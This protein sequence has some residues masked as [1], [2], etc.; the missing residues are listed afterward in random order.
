[1]TASVRF[2]NESTYEP[3]LRPY[4]NGSGLYWVTGTITA[5]DQYMNVSFSFAITMDADDYVEIYARQNSG[6][7]VSVHGGS[8]VGTV[9]NGFK[10][11]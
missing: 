5:Q 10:I 2:A 3:V 1:M 9:F 6:T 8:D 4:F 11:T 7:N